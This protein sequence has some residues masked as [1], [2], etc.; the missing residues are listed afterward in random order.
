MFRS[1]LFKTTFLYPSASTNNPSLFSSGEQG[2]W[3]DPSDLSTM[4]EDAAG[5]IPV[6]T[7]GQPVGLIKDKSGRN[8]HAS[9][10]VEASR[11]I[12]RTNGSL[13]WLSCNG[14]NQYLVIQNMDLTSTD[15][16]TAIVGAYKANDE[17]SIVYE[18]SPN[19]NFNAGS[20]A[21]TNAADPQ[22]WTASARGTTFSSLAQV[23]YTTQTAPD[24]AVITAMHDIAGSRS[25][26]RRNG[27]FGVDGS[28]DKG[29]GNFG[30]YP[31]HIG[32]RADNSLPFNG[33]LY[34]LIIR[35]AS[36]DEAQLASVE[37][38]MAEKT[39]VTIT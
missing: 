20:F 19:W 10:S 21:Q 6:T 2:T 13:R 36:T 28:G 26:V 25:R 38:W 33:N 37:T 18:F 15:K 4:F 35:G 3:L 17:T 31:L 12:Y 5:T 9:Q 1:L 32:I 22:F 30:N 23:A 34:G 11:P 8:N 29:T 16:V 24:T 39:G 14:I 27:V 7:D